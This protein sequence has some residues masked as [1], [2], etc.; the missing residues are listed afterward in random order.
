MISAACIAVDRIKAGNPPVIELKSVPAWQ[1]AV[2]GGWWNELSSS[3]EYRIEPELERRPCNGLNVE[4]G[5]PMPR[6]SRRSPDRYGLRWVLSGGSPLAYGLCVQGRC[7]RAK[8]E[9]PNPEK[10]PALE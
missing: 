6:C 1:W 8:E 7:P 10:G 4:I 9:I 2:V 3:C 5:Q